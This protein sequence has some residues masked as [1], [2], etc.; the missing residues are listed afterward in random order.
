MRAPILDEPLHS[1]AN[2]PPPRWVTKPVAAMSGSL[3]GCR[4]T[5]NQ[6]R[7]SPRRRARFEPAVLIVSVMCAL[8]CVD[9]VDRRAK[10]RIFSPEDPPLV[11]S[12]ATEAIKADALEQSALATL[13][14]LTMSAAEVTERLG[15][16]RMTGSVEWEW[17][18]PHVS[19]VVLKETRT[20]V[21][22][23]GGVA[24]DFHATADNNHDQGVEVIRVGGR[25]FA[26]SRFGRF[27][28]RRRDRGMAE[29]MR[30][31]VF[32]VLPEIADIFLGRIQLTPAGT[33]RVGTRTAWKYSVALR[34]TAATDTLGAK[35]R[36][37][38]A[39]EQADDEGT[40]L[41]LR[42][43]AGRQ[44]QSVG[45]EVLVDGESAVVL[46]ARI[47]GRVTVPSDAGVAELHLVGTM[48]L[49]DIGEKQKIAVPDNALPDEDKPPGIA[50]VLSRFGI[51]RRGMDGGSAPGVPEPA[52]EA[53]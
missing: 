25:V 9:E 36:S 48:A 12:K 21:S 30:A 19:P 28:E 39:I 47:D 14:V 44:L 41:R 45:G 27:R 13:R 52:G 31:Q 33:E 46:R 37:P 20:V 5:S 8:G 35:V 17:R 2:C 6:G 7:E 23:P 26:R 29:R 38:L 32:G 4:A 18:Q 42:Y 22:G 10:Q 16:H 11:V 24:G 50:E 40:A 49:A 43:Y 3:G 1:V 53:E 15:S 34:A 51:E